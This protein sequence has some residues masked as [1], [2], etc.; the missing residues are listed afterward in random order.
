MI[1]W[2]FNNL[3]KITI[4]LLV[5]FFLY[6]F[7]EAE[8]YKVS[9]VIKWDKYGYYLYLPSLF[10]YNDLFEL[11]FAAELS[12]KYRASD[13]NFTYGT[14]E[15][16]DGK[17]VLKFT[18]GLAILYLPFFL[19]GHIYALSSS[20]PADGLSLPYQLSIGLSA[21]FYSCI[22]LFF[23]SKVLRKYFSDVTVAATL[24][25][26]ALATNYYHYIYIEGPMAHGYLFTLYTIT[27]FATQK[28][29]E[30]KAWGYS[31]IIG[32]TLGL[33]ILIRPTSILFAFLP[34]LW[35]VRNISQFK[36][37]INLFALHKYHVLSAIVVAILI[38]SIQPIYW[39]LATGNILYYSYGSEGSFNFLHPHIYEGLFS[40]KKGWF[41]YTPAMFLI[42]PGFILLWKRIPQ[43]FWPI[44]IFTLINIYIVFSWNPW[45]YGG[46]FG[47]RALIESYAILAIPIA[48][49]ISWV[50]R[51]KLLTMAF[52]PLISLLIYINTFQSYQ[53]AV[54]IMH[55]ENMDKQEYWRIFLKDKD[56]LQQ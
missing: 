39:F 19:L 13:D 25:V 5:I 50:F 27:M 24:I 37:R 23:L 29:Y 34:I 11:D 35:N 38:V 48:C 45:W 52:I 9:S 53:R 31:I 40:Y 8:L 18:S 12:E 44:L 4:L 56:D 21:I 55:W 1:R 28:W 10:I 32:I 14:T 46:S 22:G 17:R 30:K 47:M 26:I 33:C 20:F 41:V 15:T 2:I 6:K 49:L 51:Y 54:N 43:L 3:S 36:E 16:E 7:K 42:L